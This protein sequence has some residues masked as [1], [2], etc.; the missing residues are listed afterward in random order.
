[1]LSIQH[2]IV[3]AA[4]ETADENDRANANLAASRSSEARL[5]RENDELRATLAA[6]QAIKLM[7]QRELCELRCELQVVC[8]VRDKAQAEAGQYQAAVDRQHQELTQARTHERELETECQKLLETSARDKAEIEGLKDNLGAKD[9]EHENQLSRKDTEYA[10]GLRA[11]DVEIENQRVAFEK[12]IAQ[13]TADL[14]S[15]DTQ[16]RDLPLVVV[17]QHDQSG[18]SASSSSSFAHPTNDASTHLPR[19]HVSFVN[20]G[21]DSASFWASEDSVTTVRPSHPQLAVRPS[22]ILPSSMSENK[23]SLLRDASSLEIRVSSTSCDLVHDR[24]SLPGID[25]VSSSWASAR[26]IGGRDDAHQVSVPAP[27]RARSTHSNRPANTSDNLFGGQTSLYAL[28]PD[29]SSCW[30]MPPGA[31]EFPHRSRPNPP[32]DNVSISSTSPQP[33]LVGERSTPSLEIPRGVGSFDLLH[34][35]LTLSGLDTDSFGVE[36]KASAVPTAGPSPPLVATPAICTSAKA[37]LPSTAPEATFEIPSCQASF[38][39]VHD[40]ISLSNAD[41]DSFWVGPPAPSLSATDKIP[42]TPHATAPS[43]ELGSLELPSD[44][45]SFNLLHDGLSF[46]LPDA[47]S[48][49]AGVSEPEPVLTIQAQRPARVIASKAVGS[50]PGPS[51]RAEVRSSSKLAEAKSG[52]SKHTEGKTTRRPLARL[53]DAGNTPARPRRHPARG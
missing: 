51:K 3:E 41:A 46:P 23:S 49:G 45:G 35:N 20:I 37:A 22:P 16:L 4:K 32:C 26:D 18:M 50:K 25:Q 29:T 6:E 52:S 12:E 44:M 40:K 19:D 21:Q 13:L 14:H 7:T 1:M 10:E 27:H 30:R 34:D 8:K 11:K 17:T 9:A 2:Q 15:K 33:S 43:G 48:F 5:G 31:P 39:I 24:I 36:N 38:N 42:P 28:S 53:V 47:N